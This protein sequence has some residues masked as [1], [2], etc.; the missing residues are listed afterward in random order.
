MKEYILAHDLGT[1]G[2]K[3]TL[4]S[5]EGELLKSITESYKSRYFNDNW[6]EQNPQ[7]WWEAVCKSSQ[8]LLAGIDTDKIAAVCF[9]GHMMGCLPVDRNGTPLAN[10]MLYCDQRAKTSIDRLLEK[11][12]VRE[13]YAI[14]GHRPNPTLTNPK[15]MWLKENAR[16]IYDQ[17]YK[18]LQA[19]DY[20]NFRLTGN[21]Y[22]DYNDA[23]GT[24]V[25]DLNTLDWSD[26][27][28]EA[29]GI[30][31]DKYP[32]AV[33]SATVIGEVTAEAAKATGIKAGTPVVAGTGDGGAANIGIG[34]IEP[35]ITYCN[36]GS[37]SWISSSS[38]EML[39]DPEMAIFTLA[40]PIEGLLQPTGPMMTGGRSFNWLKDEL[41]HAETIEAAKNSSSPYELIN[42][43]IETSPPGARGLLFMPYLLG[44]R[45]PWWNSMSKGGIL[46]L[47][48]EHTRADIFRAIIEGISANLGLILE[49]F[50]NN[51]SFDRVRAIGGGAQ[52]ELWCQVLADTFNRH[53]E[54]PNVLEGASSMGAAIIGG[55][56]VGALPSFAAV[57][58]FI[59]IQRTTAPN[60]ENIQIYKA[61]KE[62]LRRV[63]TVLHDNGIFELF[64][65]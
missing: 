47:S 13:I 62:A 55:V 45:S 15:V 12:S 8:E 29:S 49:V 5:L 57:D 65:N 43:L 19:K 10:H 24:L 26:T 58:R 23:S 33:P 6:A 25:F 42:R 28:L 41:A 17:T 56:G 59:K 44:E 52:G 40:H 63:Y 2:N 38:T 54:V 37:S 46:G 30:D 3:A 1:S 27:I 64:Q 61:K 9:S 7:D 21:M 31:R 36:L 4:F 51:Q 34:A 16:D 32:E 22:S 48:L 53:I 18:F 20:I 60:P 11:L 35:G 14:T 39:D 50:A